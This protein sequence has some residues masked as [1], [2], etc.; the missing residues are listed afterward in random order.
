MLLN[1]NELF[2]LGEFASDYHRRI[3]GRE[4]A[5]KLKLN[6]KTVSNILKKLEKENIVK[7]SFEGRNKYYFLNEFNSYIKEIIKAIEISRKVKFLSEHSKI[8]G[9]FERLEQ[10][11]K[12]ILVIFGSYA[13]NSATEKS[14]LDIFIL[15]SILDVKELEELYKVKINVVQ[16]KRAKFDKNDHLIKEVIKNHIILKGVEEFVE[17]VW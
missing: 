11:T 13:K 15:G 9:L 7:F 14:D 5:K 12:G 8:E 6:Q 10:R 3:Y 1:K 4:A 17:L 16:L 2:I